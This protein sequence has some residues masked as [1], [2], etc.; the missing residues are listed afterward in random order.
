MR[1]RLFGTLVSG[2]SGI[3]SCTGVFDAAGGFYRPWLRTVDREKET[4]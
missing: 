4:A 3:T 1:S 2:A